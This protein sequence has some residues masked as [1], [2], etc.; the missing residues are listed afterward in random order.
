MPASHEAEAKENREWAIRCQNEIA[1]SSE[2]MKAAQKEARRDNGQ[3]QLIQENI[4]N[5]SA[6]LLRPQSEPE[7]IPT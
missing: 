5:R 2:A 7:C 1:K 4:D 3:I 6:M